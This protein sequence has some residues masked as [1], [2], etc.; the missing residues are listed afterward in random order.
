MIGNA[1]VRRYTVSAL[2]PRHLWVNIGMYAIGLALIGMLNTLALKY[3]TAYRGDVRLCL[4]SVYG[5]LLALQFLLLWVW[6][7]YNAGNALR[8]EMLHKSYD[9][10]RL[11]PLSPW[12]KLVGVAV[13]R[14]LLALA[15]AAVTAIVQ[16]IVGF[17]GE[18]PVFLQMQITFTLLATTALIWCVAVLSSIRPRKGKRQ[19]RGV[20][21]LLL[22]FVALW[23]TPV[24]L[25][26]VMLAT[27][28]TELNDWKVSFFSV[29]FPGLLLVG[30]IATYGATW[31]A[32]GAMR[33][34]FRSELTI[35]SPSGAYGF[36]AGCL[37]I[38]LGLFWQELSKGGS[39]VW[40]GYA[41]VTHLLVLIMPF[42]LLRS[43]EQ[44]MELTYDCAR[45]HGGGKKL[46]RSF[47]AAANPPTWAGLYALWAA[48]VVG[49]AAIAS[50]NLAFWALALVVCVF[51][52][53]AVF[54]LLAELAVVGASRNEKLKFFAGFLAMLYLF[55]P[56]LLA[57]VLETSALWSFSY[58]GIWVAIEHY[59]SGRD[60]G[61]MLLLSPLLLNVLLVAVL[62]LIIRQRYIG[63][64]NA[65]RAMS[66]RNADVPSG[67]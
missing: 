16:W 67:A 36:L 3:G 39:D 52:A 13:G 42:G 34:L 45:R 9:F 24:V 50:L 1:L 20:S 54:L 8:E 65:R 27:A 47:L 17:A 53:W 21:A 51:F 48:F 23:I 46:A 56:M 7:G 31:A 18:V 30:A 5:Q 33:R 11:L 10:F 57:I 2:R 66:A 59:A 41:V 29:D 32:F 43:Y 6:G 25:Q 64:V 26:L 37:V 22:I 28:V 49:V 38:A 12:Q 15:L 40:L 19:Q 60:T 62:T 35:F 44:Y 55:L 63:I 4:R 61:E 14:N 58:F